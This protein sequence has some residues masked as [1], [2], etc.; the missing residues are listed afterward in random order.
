MQISALRDTEGLV[1][2]THDTNSINWVA[3]I[4]ANQCECICCK[5]VHVAGP[6]KHLSV[7]GKIIPDTVCV[8][9]VVSLFHT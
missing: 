5:S 6:M 4:G 3:L 8:H 9:T 7:V 1:G 2:K